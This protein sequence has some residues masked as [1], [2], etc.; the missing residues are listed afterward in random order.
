VSVISDQGQQWVSQVA[1]A[2]YLHRLKLSP[3]MFEDSLFE[4]VR[5]S[6]ARLQ[7]LPEVWAQEIA[8]E[9]LEARHVEAA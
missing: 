9:T 2:L 8:L 6:L 3:G 5:A 1:A 4:H 7:S